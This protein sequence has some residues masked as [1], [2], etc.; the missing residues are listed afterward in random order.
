MTSIS[1]GSY[2]VAFGGYRGFRVSGFRVLGGGNIGEIRGHMRIY[3]GSCA[4]TVLPLG[5]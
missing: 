5:L 4:R 2:A 3:E 1:K